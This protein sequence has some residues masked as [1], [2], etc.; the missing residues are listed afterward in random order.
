MMDQ[1]LDSYEGVIKIADDIII[2]GKNGMGCDRRLHN[3]W[4]A[5]EHGLVLGKKC[6]VKSNS[7]GMCLWQAW[8]HPDAIKVSAVKEMPV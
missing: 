8:S 6:G 7:V 5:G 3:L 2:Y 1:I 4:V